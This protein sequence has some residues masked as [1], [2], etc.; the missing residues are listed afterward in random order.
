MRETTEW[1]ETVEDGWNVLVGSDYDAIVRAARTFAPGRERSDVFGK[2][3]AARA[4]ARV[5]GQMEE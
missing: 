4:I 1:V 5:V 2:G 3:E